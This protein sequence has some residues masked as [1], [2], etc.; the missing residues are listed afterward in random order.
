MNNG[1]VEFSRRFKVVY[2]FVDFVRYFIIKNRYC[3]FYIIVK[4]RVVRKDNG[5]C[6]FR[7]IFINCF[8][9]FRFVFMGANCFK[10]LVFYLL[11]YNRFVWIFNVFIEGFLFQ[12]LRVVLEY[13]FFLLFFEVF[14]SCFVKYREFY[15]FRN[16]FGVIFVCY[17]KKDAGYIYFFVLECYQ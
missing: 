12:K 15:V 17:I 6:D 1:V 3:F 10:Q 4:F 13:F 14:V 8:N 5:G 2:K 9:R 11:R 7:V 16:Q